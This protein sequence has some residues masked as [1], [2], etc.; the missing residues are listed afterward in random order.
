MK[1]YEIKNAH[2]DSVLESFKKHS[3]VSNETI[4]IISKPEPPDAIVTINGNT[5]WIEITDAFFNKEFAESITTYVADDK[6]YKPIP[7][8]KGPYIEPDKHFSNVL[9]GVIVK[10]YDKASIGKV[11]KEHGAGILLVGIYNPFSH[12]GVL[13]RTEK[14]KILNAINSKEQRFNKIYLYS[15]HG[16]DFYKLL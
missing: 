1:R 16:H 4:E 10:K 7:K 5:T 3:A 11:Y 12:A 13:V 9:E 2:E 15:I 14:E 8:R 6:V